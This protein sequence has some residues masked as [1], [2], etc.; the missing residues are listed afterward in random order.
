MS[1]H[2]LD[3]CNWKS[4]VPLCTLVCQTIVTKLDSATIPTLSPY[5]SN[6]SYNMPTKPTKP[7]TRP[8]T[9]LK[10]AATKKPPRKQTQKRAP[11]PE[12]DSVEDVDDDGT[13][14]V[15]SDLETPPKKKRWTQMPESEPEDVHFDDSN[16]EIILVEQTLNS[17]GDDEVT[18]IISVYIVFFAKFLCI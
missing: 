12:P 4:H 13:S 11:I 10:A 6:F 1:I 2:L 17:S 16:V 14:G 5:T 3:K 7:R 9:L 15:E 18:V 8:T